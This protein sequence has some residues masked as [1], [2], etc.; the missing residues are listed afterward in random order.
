MD[1]GGLTAAGAGT[2]GEAAGGKGSLLRPKLLGIFVSPL[3]CSARRAAI[4]SSIDI[5]FLGAS[6]VGTWEVNGRVFSGT[7]LAW[8]RP[9][10]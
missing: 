5:P 9:V 10:G 3:A 1:G 6:G 7:V 2:G 4:S 8:G